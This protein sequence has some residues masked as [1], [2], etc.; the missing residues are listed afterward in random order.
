M[1]IFDEERYAK[2]F[3]L[4]TVQVPSMFE[5]IKL[6][7]RY[8]HHVLGLSPFDNYKF[9]VQWL[10]SHCKIF[11]D[12]S[13]SQVITNAIKKAPRYPFYKISS[14][15]IYKSE[16]QKILE[17]HNLRMEKIMFVM[18]CLAKLRSKTHNYTN[19]YEDFSISDIFKMARVSV[20]SDERESYIY[21]LKELGYL[22]QPKKNNATG[23]FVNIIDESNDTV[24]FNINEGDFQELAYLYLKQT[25]QGKIIR[26]TKCSKLIKANNKNNGLCDDCILSRGKMKK[27]LCIECGTSVDV[28]EKDTRSCRCRNCQ[29]RYRRNYHKEFKKQQRINEKCQQTKNNLQ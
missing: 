2:N 7:T 19:G 29:E 3:I 10:K 20:A 5:K 21:Q 11:S 27:I 28:Y 23:M 16:I 6:L 15:Q 14:V 25:K 18:L 17:L 1:I 9:T 24:L 22:N 12:Y 4:G 8:N 26:C 13:C